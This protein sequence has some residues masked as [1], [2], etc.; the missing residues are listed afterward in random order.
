MGFVNSILASF[1]IV[2]LGM[3]CLFGFLALLIVG[4]VIVG[5][6]W[7][8]KKGKARVVTGERNFDDFG[9]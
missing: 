9:H 3:M 1:G 6:V 2:T 7:G 5:I 8:L 4:I